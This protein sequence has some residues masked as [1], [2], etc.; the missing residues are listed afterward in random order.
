MNFTI[1]SG[2]FYSVKRQLAI[3]DDL[4]QYEQLGLA[5]GFTRFEK[6][7]ITGFRYGIKWIQGY[8]FT[9]GREYRV[10]IRNKENKILKINFL[11]LYGIKKK[12]FNQ[13]YAGILDALW[14]CYFSKV[15]N[16]LLDKFRSGQD[17]KIGRVVISGEGITITPPGGFFKEQP[18]MIPW[19]KASTRNYHTNFNIYSKEDAAHINKGYS[20]MDDWNTYIL[21]YVVQTILQEKQLIEMPGVK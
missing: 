1:P 7:D 16:A 4:L 14:N 8:Q 21:Y 12:E 20:Y 5:S 15:T 17:I 2:L 6:D 18:K 10:F 9:I 11:S 13:L 3:E 19:E